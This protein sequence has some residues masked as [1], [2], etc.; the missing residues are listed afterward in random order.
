M[1]QTKEADGKWLIS[2][3]KFSKDRFLN[4]GPLKPEN[5]QL[6]DIAGGKEMKIVHDGPTFAEP[7]DCIIVKAAI[8]NPKRVWDRNDAM[9]ADTVAMVKADGVD[10]EA[11]EN[12][13]RNGNKVKVYM[14]STAP[15]F[16]LN[17]FKVKE[18]DEVTVVVTNID[19][20]DD[21]THGFTLANYG[22]AFEIGPLQTASVTFKADRPG[23]HWF[24]CMWFCHAL[25]MEMRGRMLVAPRK[26]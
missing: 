4:V 9:F 25:H 19:D 7:H 11:A 18:G 5:D 26:A 10:P 3:N 15:T 13:I 2:L 22:I 20:V 21:L 12:V 1:G 6:I 16:S 17:E 23:V 14:H 24:Y 8:V